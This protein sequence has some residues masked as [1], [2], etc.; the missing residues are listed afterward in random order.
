MLHAKNYY[1]HYKLP[2]FFCFSELCVNGSVR[3]TYPNQY[4]FYGHVQ[5]CIGGV[6]GSIC[7]NRYWDNNDAS[8]LCKQLGFSPYGRPII[9]DNNIIIINCF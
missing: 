4:Y 9:L 8:V 7:R 2:L 5:V 3:L 6:W 1:V